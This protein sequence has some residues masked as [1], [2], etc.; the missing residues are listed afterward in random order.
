MPAY[1]LWRLGR[2]QALWCKWEL[3]VE[4]NG[5]WIKCGSRSEDEPAEAA[6]RTS[7][8]GADEPGVLSERGQTQVC[9]CSG[10]AG[11]AVWAHPIDVHYITTSQRGWPSLLVEVWAQ[12]PGGRNEIAGYGVAHLPSAA[13]EYDIDIPLWRPV[14]LASSRTTLL[15]S[16]FK[17]IGKSLAGLGRSLNGVFLGVWPRLEHDLHP[18]DQAVDSTAKK[19]IVDHGPEIRRN[20][21]TVGS[22]T[23]HAKLSVLTRGFQKL[24]PGV[25]LVLEA[26]SQQAQ[27]RAAQEREQQ[28]RMASR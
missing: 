18:P 4:D 13:G 15:A 8:S 9:V 7:R 16:P 12:E 1:K 24:G 27:L 11:E 21:M 26:E 10:E 25:N 6:T 3:M 28:Q 20:I 2:P 23:V 22:G 14:D 17:H 5:R 19:V